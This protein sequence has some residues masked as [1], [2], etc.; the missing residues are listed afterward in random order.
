MLDVDRRRSSELKRDIFFI[1]IYF[2]YRNLQFC[3]RYDNSDM[4]NNSTII[5]LCTVFYFHNYFTRSTLIY[6]VI[7]NAYLIFKN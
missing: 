7:F 5:T 6:I 1:N 2:I 3:N 4:S